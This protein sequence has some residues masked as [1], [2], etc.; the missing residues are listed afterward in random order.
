MT[1]G[2]DIQSNG[3]RRQKKEPQNTPQIQTESELTLFDNNRKS[4][5]PP[6]KPENETIP[7]I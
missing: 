3:V 5:R 7:S 1:D 4:V 2:M 6:L